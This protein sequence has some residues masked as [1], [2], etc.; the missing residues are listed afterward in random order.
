[1]SSTVIPIGAD[2]RGYALKAEIVGWL[3]ARGH[4]VN[5]LGAPD[6]ERCDALDYARAR[7]PQPP[8]P[9]S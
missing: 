5:D 9:S 3:Q 6:A 8:P 7:A 2:H 1:M 4:A